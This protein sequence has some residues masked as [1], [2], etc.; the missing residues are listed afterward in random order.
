MIKVQILIHLCFFSEML[1]LCFPRYKCISST[2][3]SKNE[4]FIG[5]F[6]RFLM[7]KVIFNLKVYV[8]WSK[9]KVRLGKVYVSWSKRESAFIIFFH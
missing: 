2:H 4:L 7:F 8:S 5:N 3:Y 6:F 9:R 1:I